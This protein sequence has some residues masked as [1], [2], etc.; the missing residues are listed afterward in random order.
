MDSAPLSEGDYLL[1]YKLLGPIGAGGMG[2]VWRALDTRLNREVALKLLPALQS[3]GPQQTQRLTREAQ[4]ASALNH[5]NIVT[6]YDINS[7]AG[8]H[9]IAMELVRGKSL[10]D[11]LRENK[12]SRA[13]AL[14]YAIA[15]SDALGKAHA[16]GIIHRDLKP[17][18]VMITSDGL[19]KVLD[20]GLAKPLGAM[21][22][23]ASSEG[24]DSADPLTLTTPGVVLGTVGYM[25][26]EQTLGGDVDARTD[27]FSFGVV[28]YEMLSG[29]RPFPGSSRQEVAVNLLWSAPQ[30]LSVLCPDMPRQIEEIV[31]RCLAS[32]PD[33]RYADCG[34]VARDLK[35]AVDSVPLS[36]SS[37]A[38]DDGDTTVFD[39]ALGANPSGMTGTW[40]TTIGPGLKPTLWWGAALLALAAL[41]WS[42]WTF[43]PRAVQH[44]RGIAVLPFTAV[45][46]E[47]RTRAFGVG[48]VMSLSSQLS[49]LQPFRDAFWVV[50]PADVIQAKAQSAKDARQM[51]GVDMVVSGSVET[52]GQRIRVTAIVSDARNQR[53]IRSGQMTEAAGDSFALQDN[54]VALVAGLLEVPLPAEVRMSAE[55]GES[56]E[57]GAED[58][59]LQGRG[60]LL[61]DINQADLAIDVFKD[62]LRRDPKFARAHAGLGEAYLDKYEFTKDP[63]WL[64]KARESCERALRLRDGTV[65]ARTVLGNIARIEG[66]YDDAASILRDV[67]TREPRNWEAW[68]RLARAYEGKRAMKD[69]ESAYRQALELQPGY[70]GGY[71]Y[72]GAFYYKQA[73]Y[74]EAV[75]SFQRAS[76]L[77]PDNYKALN[78]LAAVYLQQGRFPETERAL[79]RS[80]QLKPNPIAYNNLASL[81]FTQA[82]YSE[83][84]PMMEQAVQMGQ[85]SATMLGSLA[86]LYRLVPELRSKAGKAAADAMEVA[87]KQLAVN[88]HD[89]LARA[90]LAWLYAEQ[91]DKQTALRE[92][93]T[94]LKEAP[95]DGD[96]LFRSV[97]VHELVGDREGAL[98]AYDS[99]G[100][101][102]SNLTEVNQRPELKSLRTDPRF[103]EKKWQTTK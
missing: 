38:N 15:L 30:P 27:V 73:R 41:V 49:G 56:R 57:P 99:L 93:S 78:N 101:T 50:P 29:Y 87:R 91:G 58:Y 7:D 79:R 65:E 54:L 26:P 22:T 33:A 36:V 51:F 34:A 16:A 24:W 47:D 14:R 100:K 52:T 18:N 67:V 8:R 6:I 23:S 95:K 45:G 46:S 94:A 84:V 25:S 28:L 59:Y 10:R 44:Q 17:G 83:S 11:I 19:L 89:T 5:P 55:S 35:S 1:H 53:M 21:L 37:F 72:L 92:I 88:P 4:C 97:L 81:Y 85:K 60:Y 69:A 98:A 13:E 43:Y 82:R 2:V 71:Q 74:E 86:H 40:A 68:L 42:A 70:P 77:A 66:R 9:F 76:Q 3:E 12:L 31:N 90:D 20:F 80:L 39:A 64:R 61:S 63:E 103:R 75:R 96:V 32:N 102:G 62:A 48:L